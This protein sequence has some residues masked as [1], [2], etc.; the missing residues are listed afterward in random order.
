[1]DQST[2]TELVTPDESNPGADWQDGDAWLADG[3]F[4]L[5]LPLPQLRRFRDLSKMDWPSLEITEDGLEIGATCRNIELLEFEYPSEWTAGG[6]LGDSIRAFLAGFK[7]WSVS[8]AGGNICTSIPAGPITTMACALEAEYLLISPDGSTRLL[9]AIDFVT[10]NNT[11]V[12]RPG[13]LLRKVLISFE[14]LR[15]N[16]VT[17]RFSMTKAGR[18]SI[19]LVGTTDPDSGEFLL[20]VS[21]ATIHPVHLRFSAVPTAAELVKELDKQIPFDLYFDDPNGTPEHR[22]HMTYLFAGEIRDDLAS[23]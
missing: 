17:R 3:T 4:L 9:P 1:M 5:S 6:L 23:A 12:L 16:Y 11:N 20:T 8:T 22:K 10:G 19:F 14:A 15:R 7:V 2:V 21:A 18:S 13:E